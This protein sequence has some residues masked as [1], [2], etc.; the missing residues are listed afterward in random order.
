[1]VFLVNYVGKVSSGT[2]YVAFQDQEK[3]LKSSGQLEPM[4]N[5]GNSFILITL[6]NI[7]CFQTSKFVVQGIYI[8]V[9]TAM[10]VQGQDLNR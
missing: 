8:Y 6:C 5:V 10:H 7:D 3:I 1:M 2:F 9:Y 4:S